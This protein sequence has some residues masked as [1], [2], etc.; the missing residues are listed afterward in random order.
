MTGS[1]SSSKIPWYS[2]HDN[3]KHTVICTFL[4]WQDHFHFVIRCSGIRTTD[5]LWSLNTRTQLWETSHKCSGHFKCGDKNIAFLPPSLWNFTQT[6]TEFHKSVFPNRDGPCSRE[7]TLCITDVFKNNS[8]AAES[9]NLVLRSGEF[10]PPEC[11]GRVELNQWCVRVKSVSRPLVGSF[12]SGCAYEMVNV[13]VQ[14]I[15]CW[16]G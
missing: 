14:N 7:Q 9:K 3:V 1:P 6:S 8:S 11:P 2:D 5:L 16:F 12:L 4:S 10:F 13:N 15:I